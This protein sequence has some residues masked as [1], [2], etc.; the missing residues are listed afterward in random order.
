MMT[1]VWSCMIFD[2]R[3]QQASTDPVKYLQKNMFGSKLS[4]LKVNIAKRNKREIEKKIRTW[5]YLPVLVYY[6][7]TYIYL[8]TVF[9]PLFTPQGLYS[10]LNRR[11]IMTN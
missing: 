6:I 7:H 9:K 5:N 4:I 11:V 10:E 2:N 1:V 3:C 8:T